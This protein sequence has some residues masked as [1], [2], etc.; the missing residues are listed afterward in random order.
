M[1]VWDNERACYRLWIASRIERDVDSHKWMEFIYVV[2]AIYL[3]RLILAFGDVR[4]LHFSV[5][6]FA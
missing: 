1:C 5:P 6:K 4:S 2:Y 3:S